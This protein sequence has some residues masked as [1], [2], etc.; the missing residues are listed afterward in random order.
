MRSLPPASAVAIFL[1]TLGVAHATPFNYTGSLQTYTVTTTGI[2]LIFADG[3]QGGTGLR[4]SGGIGA[5]I[6]GEILLTS[7]TILDVIVGGQ[8][9]STAPLTAGG[10]GGGGGSFVFIPGAS[11]PLAV[12]GGGGG[13]GG[14]GLYIAGVPF[15]GG[16]PGNASTSGSASAS[17]EAGGS[18]GA[19]GTSG[20]TALSAGGGAGFFS[21]GTAETNPFSAT[22]GSTGPSFAGGNPSVDSTGFGGFG[23]GGGSSEDGGG[24]GGGYSGGGGGDSNPM[25][26]DYGGGGGSYLA[27][28]FTDQDLH[29]GGSGQVN[30]FVSITLLSATPPATTPEPPASLLLATGLGL[31]SLL[32]RR[33]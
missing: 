31:V 19:G 10:G 25:S 8:G 9:G 15:P 2:Y 32:R 22:P 28:S 1:A 24:G 5:Q 20:T 14:G 18:N 26:T 11:Q 4:S 7:G 33:L 3:A 16:S 13:G 12:A 29:T 23:G 6:D 30:G 21:S 17:G 27:S